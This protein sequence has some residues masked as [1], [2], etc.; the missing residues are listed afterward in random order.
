MLELTTIDIL[1]SL[2]FLLKCDIDNDAVPWSC[3]LIGVEIV[4]LYFG[5]SL[6]IYVSSLRTLS[7]ISLD[8]LARK[9]FVQMYK[10]M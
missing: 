2:N 7:K 6:C 8:V 10:M 5:D 9:S 1:R 3:R 4:I